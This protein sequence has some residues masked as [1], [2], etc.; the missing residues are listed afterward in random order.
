M[1][2]PIAT[3]GVLFLCAGPA[4]PVVDFESRRPRADENGEPLSAIQLVGLFSDG[5]EV[6]RVQLAGRVPELVVGA[7]V[8]VEA[9]VANYWTMGDRSGVSFK[10]ATLS[11]APVVSA[12]KSVA[13]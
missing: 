2:L 7:P 4:V 6:I 8:R 13:S 11:A 5:A 9:L 12:G 3:D 10:A 1:K